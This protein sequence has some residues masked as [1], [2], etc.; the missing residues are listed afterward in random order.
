MSKDIVK[1]TEAAV[2]KAEQLQEDAVTEHAQAIAPDMLKVVEKVARGRMLPGKQRAKPNEML[3]AATQV[4]DRAQGKPGIRKGE[5]NEGGSGVTI[6][7]EA[8]DRHAEKAIPIQATKPKVEEIG[9][10]GTRTAVTIAEF[11]HAEK[12]QRES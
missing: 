4:L 3:A 11:Q 10:G 5:V 7:I 6:I 2:Q 12:V 1:A 9:E 8:P